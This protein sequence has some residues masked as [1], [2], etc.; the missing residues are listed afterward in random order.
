MSNPRILNYGFEYTTSII[1]DTEIIEWCNYVNV[2]CSDVAI[3]VYL[4]QANGQLPG[5]ILIIKIDNSGFACKINPFD[6]ETIMGST[7][8]IVLNNQY[9]W[10]LIFGDGS[11]DVKVMSSSTYPIATNDQA[12]YIKISQLIGQVVKSYDPVNNITTDTVLLDTA[13]SNLYDLIKPTNSPTF[14]SINL[15]NNTNQIA[16]GT[17][18]KTTVTMSS[19]T[20]NRTVTLPDANSNTIVPQ[21]TATTHN[22]VT[23]I[24]SDG[25]QQISQPAFTDISGTASN[26][27]TTATSSNTANTIVS[28]DASGNF[29]AGTITASLTGQASLN[30]VFINSPTAGNFAFTD[31]NG[32]TV[33]NGIALSIDSTT[34]TDTDVLTSKATQTAIQNAFQASPLPNIISHLSSG[35]F[36]YTPSANISYVII[37]IWGAGGASAGCPSC[38]SSQRSAGGAG[39][40]GG[41]IKALIPASVLTG[42]SNIPIVVGAGGVGVSAGNGGNG[43][44]SYI[45]INGYAIN[46]NGGNG[47]IMM[48]ASSTSN[49]TTTVAGGTT[50]NVV[51]G[52]TTLDRCTG[53]EGGGGALIYTADSTQERV[54]ISG[55][56]GGSGSHVGNP[57][58]YGQGAPLEVVGLAG[59]AAGVGGRAPQNGGSDPARIGANGADGAVIIYEFF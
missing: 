29:S 8:P 34:N 13:L 5:Q 16:L 51:G 41:Y 47:G 35:S 3:D 53:G 17:G 4:P 31:T 46:G 38:G 21:A 32:Q 58:A 43:G 52:T 6:T 33:D 25:I 24:T 7:N 22:W 49:V 45:A 15:T 12:G 1:G 48:L 26:N 27:Q 55:G 19:L 57:P 59:T 40:G 14:A 37:E 36:T 23:N 56:S 2:T 11:N 10:C 28:R 50:G 18:N 20:G 54:L 44:A 30:Q 42:L 9:D 39:G